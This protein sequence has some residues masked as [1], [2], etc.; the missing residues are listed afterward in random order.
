[1]TP[2]YERAAVAAA[3]TLIKY[4][5]NSAPVSPL[6]ILKRLPGVLV[7]SFE[8]LA[9]DIGLARECVISMMGD[10]NQ[11]ACTTVNM[12]PSGPKYLVAYNYQLPYSLAQRA[13]ARE[14]GHIILR[15]DGSRPEDVRTEEARAFAHHLLVPRPL[16]HAIL[17]T[18][19]RLTVDLLGNL[20]GCYDY[21][22][23]CMRKQ[24]GVHV[25]PEL[26]RIIRDN[27]TP[28]FMN[29]FSFQRVASANDAS[30]LA[31]LGSYMEGYEE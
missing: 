13:L 24:P 21:C 19:L 12:T 26:N 1:M 2:D 30:A 22:L 23:S 10:H 11:D 27:F 25:P 6:P 28:Y 20:T 8:S 7:V 18:N 16:I 5:I 3:E 29:F 4:G 9:N 15:H 31:D 14:L 17:E